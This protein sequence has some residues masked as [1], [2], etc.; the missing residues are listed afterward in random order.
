MMVEHVFGGPWTERKLRCLRDYLTAYRTIFT[1]NAKARFFQTWYVDAF[2]GTGSR[3]TSSATPLLDIY[4]DSEAQAYQDGSARIA[5]GLASPFDHYL[6]IE[7]S[8][9]RLAELQSLVQSDFAPLYPRCVF[10]FGDAN[11]KL[12]LWCKERDWS[13]E[14]AVVFLDLRWTPSVGQESG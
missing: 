1:G 11:V 6:F 10:Q 3:S 13:K 8:K 9:A 4:G 14:R 7:R 2:A 12:K 5:L